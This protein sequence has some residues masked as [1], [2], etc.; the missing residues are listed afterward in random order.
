MRIIK[1]IVVPRSPPEEKAWSPA[2]VSNTTRMAVL[3]A[4]SV[5][6]SHKRTIISGEKALRFSGRL[7][8]MVAM[9]SLTS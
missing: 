4:I 3:A 2:P 9:L 7:R 1:G 5:Q 6:I 8:V